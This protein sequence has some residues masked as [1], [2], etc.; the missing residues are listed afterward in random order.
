[1]S[2]PQPLLRFGSVTRRCLTIPILC[3][4]LTGCSHLHQGSS[5]RAISSTPP[6][7][8]ELTAPASV[9][10]QGATTT[11]PVGKYRA[12]YED[13]HAYYFEAPG[14][15]LVDDIATYAFDGGVYVIKGERAPT[16]WYVIR[17][18]GRRTMGRFKNAPL[19]KV[20]PQ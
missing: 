6:A 5:F 18:N 17:P 9:S 14:K 15:V 19:Y 13:D 7:S 12:V 11:F 3:G 4:F 10:D 8:I 16:H 1:M 20:L 2:L